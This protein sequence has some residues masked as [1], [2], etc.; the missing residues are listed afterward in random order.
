MEP[1]EFHSVTEIE[2]GT[3]SLM[4]QGTPVRRYS[5]SVDAASGRMTRHVP[6]EFR[7]NQLRSVL[8]AACQESV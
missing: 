2:D 3:V 8:S 5:T 4:V 6:I 1:S 7:L